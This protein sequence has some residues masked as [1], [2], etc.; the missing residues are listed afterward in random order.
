MQNNLFSGIQAG[1]FV[2]S[3]MYRL[4]ELSDGRS[5]TTLYVVV[6]TPKGRHFRHIQGSGEFFYDVEGYCEEIC[7]IAPDQIRWQQDCVVETLKAGQKLASEE[8]VE[9]S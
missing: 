9:I 7:D 8:W 3:Q 4:V 1:K 6:S 5:V 2:V